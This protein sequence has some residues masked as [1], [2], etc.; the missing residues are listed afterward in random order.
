[1]TVKLP[2]GGQTAFEV[3]VRAAL[4]QIKKILEDL[5]RRLRELEAA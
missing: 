2:S 4:V 1:M 5:E 3:E